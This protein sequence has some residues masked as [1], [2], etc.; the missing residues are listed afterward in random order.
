MSKIEGF[1]GLHEGIGLVA[2]VFRVD[3]RGLAGFAHTYPIAQTRHRRRLKAKQARARAVVLRV[4]E[5]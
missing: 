3:R 1:E 2:L 4:I 5:K